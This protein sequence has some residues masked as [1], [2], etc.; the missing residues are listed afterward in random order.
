M[1]TQPT[2]GLGLVVKRPFFA[3]STAR[4]RKR[5]SRSE[6]LWALIACA[7]ILDLRFNPGGLLSQATEIAEDR[8][9]VI[10]KAMSITDPSELMKLQA[11]L[12]AAEQKKAQAMVKEA[13]TLYQGVAKDLFAPIQ[14]QMTKAF[15]QAS[16]FKAV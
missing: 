6:V 16:K 5:R 12:I 2:R 14:A 9:A 13:T 1:I 11:D 10:M 15:E 7:L 4:S 8:V 3:S